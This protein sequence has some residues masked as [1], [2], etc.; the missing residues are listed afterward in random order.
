MRLALLLLFAVATQP[1]PAQPD[2]APTRPNLVLPQPDLAPTPPDLAPPQPNPAPDSLAPPQ[3]SDAAALALADT[4]TT[5]P[6]QRRTCIEYA[7]TAASDTTYASNHPSSPGGRVSLNVRCDGAFANGWRGVFSDRFDDFFA[8][9]ASAQSVNTLKEA[10]VSY[11]HD[12]TFLADLGRINVREGVALAYNPT[13]YFRANAT[14]ALISIDPGTL[15]DER[16]GTLMSRFQTLWSSGSLTGIFAPRVSAPP[17]DSTFNPDL[18]ATNSANRWLLIWSQR[19]A[20]DFQPQL[21]LTGTEHQSPQAGLN[22]THL[23]NPATVA[24]LEWS[25]GRSTT[26]AFRSTYGPP[27]P[28]DTAFHSRSSAGMTY[29]TSYKLS[30]TLEYEYDTA[31]PDERE[32]TL[33]RTG[34]IP[35]YIRYRE[36]AAAQAEPAT[37]QNLFAYAH[38]D[39]LGIDRLGLTTFIRFDP[40]DHSRLNW[41]EAR[42]HW[43]HIDIALQWQHNTGA[44]TSDL[45]QWPERQSWLALIDYYP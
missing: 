36:Y 39:D 40:Y 26:N 21:S 30:L 43:Q 14:R 2:L 4:T 1:A 35:P 34:P 17:N 3:D 22:L 18:G 27:I 12:G 33:L 5:E 13:D 31:A 32:W 24:Y 28:N 20:A 25:G 9:G 42:Y 6:T 7:E 41:T 19:L 23:L 45:A 10:Y 15:R 16:M 29:T 8:R 37:R 38:W 44:P 11:Q